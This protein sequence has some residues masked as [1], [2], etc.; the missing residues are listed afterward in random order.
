MTF[1]QIQ[2]D[3]LDLLH[4]LQSTGQY[5]LTKL[6]HYINRGYYDFVRRTKSYELTMDVVTVADQETYT[7]SDLSDIVESVTITTAG[8]TYV[9]GTLSFAT[10]NAT[11]TYAVTDAA[12][13]ST[14]ITSKGS[15]HTSTPVV[16][17]SH[18]GDS[19]AV[20]A[21][22]MGSSFDYIYKLH[23]VRYVESGEIGEVLEP[24]PGG[25]SNIPEIKEYGTPR[26]YYV[27]KSFNRAGFTIGTWPINNTASD[28]L[29]L[30]AYMIP[31]KELVADS[32]IPVIPE[33]W[34]DALPYYAAYR[35]YLMFAHVKSQWHQK[36]FELKS[37]YDQ[38]VSEAKVD[39]FT[40]TD[41]N[42][43]VLDVYG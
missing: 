29:R 19:T 9:A 7:R 18:A 41:D 42:F 3:A 30:F 43:S 1:S 33:L 10:G 40:E 13:T 12:I 36:A 34:Q 6:K 16:T 14:V 2:T 22:V 35:T 28:T 32:D 37:V 15:G 5:S 26:W 4:E 38:F 8:A 20:L 23:T 27:T 31:N 21:A 25:Y 17:P 11:G 24:Y 39:Q